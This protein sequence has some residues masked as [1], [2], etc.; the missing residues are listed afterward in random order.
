MAIKV[1]AT[2]HQPRELFLTSFPPGHPE[3]GATVAMFDNGRG[4][5][6]QLVEPVRTELLVV[7]HTKDRTS[8]SK[9]VRL[10]VVL[11]PQL[12]AAF[13]QVTP[14]AYTGLKAEEKP[15]AFKGVQAL[16]GSEVRFRLL[17]NRPLRDGR[18][19]LTSG[20]LPPQAVRLKKGAD[21]EVAGAFV[22]AESGRLRFSLNDLSGL[23]SQADWEGALT[24]THDLPPEIAIVEPARDALVA[25]DLKFQAHIEASDDYG[26]RSVRIHRGVNG[27]YP[28]PKAIAY[29]GIVR[30]RHETL[31]VDLAALGVK[32]GDVISLFAEAVD[33]APQPHRARSQTVRLSVISVEDYNNF[34]REQNDLGDT[35]AKYAALTDDLQELIEQQKKLGALAEQLAGQAAKAKPGQSDEMASRLGALLERQNQLNE[36]LNQHA[37]RMEH[38]VRD[39]PLYDVERGLQDSLRQQ[40][41]QVRQSTAENEAAA[42]ELAQRSAGGRQAPSSMASD[43]KKAS[44]KQVARLGEGPGEDGHGRGA[45]PRRPEPDAGIAKGL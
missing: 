27:V 24:V 1:K 35:E 10:R 15:Y 18:L 7:A 42:R 29:A 25:L 3:Q 2:G 44:D 34:L 22:A 11:T 38:F 12:E 9:A 5:F 30:N 19:A 23:P 41:G 13:V 31:D 28:A 26:L 45:D 37:Q 21:N 43:F 32:A 16:E 20:E 4:G 33:T 40:A 17:S 8:L 6:Q 39:N 36:E 14:P